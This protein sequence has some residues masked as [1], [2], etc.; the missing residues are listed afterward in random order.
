MTILE[1]VLKVLQDAGTPLHYQE[2][3]KRVLAAGLW[4]TA[5]KTPAATINACLAVDV[6]ENGTASAFSRAGRG[7]FALNTERTEQPLHAPVDVRPADQPKNPRRGTRLL[8]L[9]FLERIASSAFAEFPRQI[10]DLAH[11]KHGV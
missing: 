11:G 7:V 8:V 4:K 9:G 2:I 10:T 5:G 3:T 1:A 6:K